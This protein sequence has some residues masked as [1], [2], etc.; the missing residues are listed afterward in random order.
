MSVVSR[1]V[2]YLWVLCDHYLVPKSGLLERVHLSAGRPL[3][4]VRPGSL[5]L[6]REINAN[7]ILRN[8][9]TFEL[10]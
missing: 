2:S 8:Y 3:A 9:P 10:V 7:D 4:E 1:F 5:G 6:V